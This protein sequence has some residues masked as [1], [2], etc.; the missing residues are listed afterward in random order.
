MH[1]YQHILMAIDS[2]MNQELIAAKRAALI[3]K[4]SGAT[5]SLLHVTRELNRGMEFSIAGAADLEDQIQERAL[6]DLNELG[7]YVGVPNAE[8]FIKQGAAN[9]TIF[10]HA[11]KNRTD[12]IIVGNRRNGL[13][14]LFTIARAVLTK[15]PCDVLIVKE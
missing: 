15:Q 4:E 2:P 12:L 13:M 8:R 6:H 5:L 7:D 11:K 1:C 3:A 9:R 14:A 10:E